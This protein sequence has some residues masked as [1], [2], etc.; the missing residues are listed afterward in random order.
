MRIHILNFLKLNVA[1]YVLRIAK[2]KKSIGNKINQIPPKPE[3]PVKSQKLFLKKYKKKYFF[4]RIPVM[5]LLCSKLP[6]K[7]G[8]WVWPQNQF[9]YLASF[10][11]AKIEI[12]PLK[13]KF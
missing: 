2:L 3:T 11:L 1:K 12:S 13:C 7:W 10:C 6:F 8:F 9:L 5:F 4:L